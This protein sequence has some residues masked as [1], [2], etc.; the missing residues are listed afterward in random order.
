MSLQE[1]YNLKVYEY[2][3]MGIKEEPSKLLAMLLLINKNNYKKISNFHKFYDFY[4]KEIDEQILKVEKD[5]DL[6]EECIKQIIAENFCPAYETRD[7]ILYV[8]EQGIS[9]LLWGIMDN[10]KTSEEIYTMYFKDYSLE[11]SYDMEELAI[12]NNIQISKLSDL[13]DK[14]IDKPSEFYQK[15]ANKLSIEEKEFIKSHLINKKCLN[16]TNGC[17]KV[18]TSEKIGLD[19]FGHPVG[20]SCIAWENSELVG[21]SKVLKIRDINNLK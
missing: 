7:K 13:I 8:Y 4:K 18:E 15:I 19:E 14:I 9:C 6:T 5:F 10:K 3:T 16:C 11:K 21:R 2:K 20:S 17:C 1:L 12:S